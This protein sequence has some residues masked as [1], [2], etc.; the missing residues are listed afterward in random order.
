MLMAIVRNRDG[1]GSELSKYD[2][3]SRLSGR[4]PSEIRA[5]ASPQAI[6]A[7]SKPPRKQAKPPK[8]SASRLR[9]LGRA[10]AS[11][12]KRGAVSRAVDAER[13]SF[14]PDINDLS[15]QHIA[16]ALFRL[17][18]VERRVTEGR[19]GRLAPIFEKY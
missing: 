11:D 12:D 4:G 1:F 8:S 19:Y 5:L 13:P 16:S 18:A 7:A 14:A 9:E 2:T 15:G 3:G 10:N 17:A 6:L